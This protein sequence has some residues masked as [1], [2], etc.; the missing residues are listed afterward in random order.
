MEDVIKIERQRNNIR[1]CEIL[2]REL[3]YINHIDQNREM[4]RGKD[5]PFFEKLQADIKE[6][7]HTYYQGT[8]KSRQS[9]DLEYIMMQIYRKYMKNLGLQL[10]MQQWRGLFY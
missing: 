2:S 10:I 6:S 8:F 1:T 9:R 4:I 5:L 3:G 7:Y